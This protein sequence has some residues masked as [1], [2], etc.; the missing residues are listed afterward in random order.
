MV[1]TVGVNQSVASTSISP[2]FIGTRLNLPG[3]FPPT[4]A[5]AQRRGEVTGTLDLG[6]PSFN[7][8]PRCNSGRCLFFF[9]DASWQPHDHLAPRLYGHAIRAKAGIVSLRN[10]IYLRASVLLPIG[11]IAASSPRLCVV[12]E[13]HR[14]QGVSSRFSRKQAEL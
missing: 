5:R 14:G 7:F 8:R 10:R 13:W 11:S 3:A 4:D 12:P 6:Q 2:L 9:K 1:D